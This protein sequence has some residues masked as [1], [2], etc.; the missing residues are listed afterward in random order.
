MNELSIRLCQLTLE[1]MQPDVDPNDIAN[2][3]RHLSH[4]YPGFCE[5]HKKKLGWNGTCG[6]CVS[7]DL[8]G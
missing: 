6:S 8:L 4:D 7:G 1:S 3:L 2:K 5:D